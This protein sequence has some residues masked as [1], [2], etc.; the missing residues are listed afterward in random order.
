[1]KLGFG[2][3]LSGPFNPTTIENA[4]QRLTA[5]I[6]AHWNVE[7]KDDGTHGAV[8]CDSIT[9]T[10]GDAQDRNA[11]TGNVSADGDGPHTFGGDVVTPLVVIGMVGTSVGTD[12]LIG[13]GVRVYDTD[14]T[15]IRYE[16]VNGGGGTLRQLRILD[17]VRQVTPL[18]LGWESSNGYW[19]GPGKD[20][21]IIDNVSLGSPFYGSG[22]GQ[23]TA[24]YTRNGYFERQRSVALG[25]WTA[26]AHAAG[27]FTASAGSWTVDSGDQSLYRYTLVGKTMTLAWAIINTDVSAASVLHLAIP[28]GFTAAATIDGTYLARDAGGAAVFATCRTVSG[29]GYIELFPTPG[30][31]GT[32][33]ITAADNTTVVGHHTFEVQ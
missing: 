17:R 5:A 18:E 11:P 20:T 14:E 22:R 21:V 2:K 25:E 29:Q 19:W 6:T 15:T 32:W 24:A 13:P 16:I 3:F 33:T 9:A 1:M 23:W 30:T 26:V 28:D 10:K 27:N 8:T 7:H 12:G 31:G 4:L